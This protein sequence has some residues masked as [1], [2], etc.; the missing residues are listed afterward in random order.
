MTSQLACD[1]SSSSAESKVLLK[2]ENLS[3]TYP[4][5]SLQNV[6]F[7]VKAGTI[8]GFIGRNGAGK[9][10]ILKC[11]EGAVYPDSGIIEYFGCPFTGNEN[12][13][14]KET[15]FELDGSDFY[16]NKKLSLIASVTSNFYTNWDESAYIQYCN[17]FNLD[18]QKRIKDLSQG[19]RVKFAL[20]LALSHK[21]KLLVLDEPTS[22]LD[23]ASREEVLD[24]LLKLAR[25]ENVGVLFSTH[26]TSDLDKCADSILYIQDG[27]II[28]SGSLPQFKDRYRVA[29]LKDAKNLHAHIYGIRETANGDT[30]LVSSDMG[31]GVSA[32]LDDIM[33]HTAHI[34]LSTNEVE[35]MTL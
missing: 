7:Q 5:F 10:T 11:L 2:V 30:A 27:R 32:T 35:G 3:K 25:H 19:M 23:P 26:I 34:D 20:A 1:I 8:M 17:L 9:S 18:Q 29:S 28:G 14:K 6:S 31:I 4:G 33:T 13:V 24:I 12:A 22:G 16:S 21:S 15:G